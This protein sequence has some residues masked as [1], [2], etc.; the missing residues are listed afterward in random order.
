MSEIINTHKLTK[1][2]RKAIH[3][4]IIKN[5]IN[6]RKEKNRRDMFEF[7]HYQIRSGNFIKTFDDYYSYNH[8][9]FEPLTH[10]DRDAIFKQ[11]PAEFQKTSN[12][13]IF[14]NTYWIGIDF[15]DIDFTMKH[16]HD[17]LIMDIYPNYS[18]CNEEKKAE[19]ERQIAMGKRTNPR[20]MI[21]HKDHP[22]LMRSVKI[23]IWRSPFVST[24]FLNVEIRPNRIFVNDDDGF[25]VYD[26]ELNL[27]K[28]I[29]PIL[30]VNDTFNFKIDLDDWNKVYIWSNFKERE[31]K[32]SLPPNEDGVEKVDELV[33]FE[34]II[35]TIDY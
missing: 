1:A 35:E 27:I 12:P 5:K 18:M 16:T 7:N 22:E 26:F 3:D 2:E 9:T 8:E 13:E 31:I 17:D 28:P 10:S 29:K 33:M 32:A 23:N 24:W 20:L 30:E 34:S 14:N 15:D 19:F 6:E 11:F 21:F 25:K 4:N